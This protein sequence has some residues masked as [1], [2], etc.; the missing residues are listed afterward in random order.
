M[1]TNVPSPP[2]PFPKTIN[3]TL[4]PAGTQLHRVYSTV[5]EGNVFNP[6]TAKLNRF[7]PIFDRLGNV[8]P[9]LYAGATRQVAIYETL[10]HDAHIKGAKRQSLSAR[11]IEERRYGGWI[12]QRDLNLATL[13]APD[14]AGFGL[15]MDQLIATNSMYYPQTARWAEAFHRSHSDIE[16]LQWPSYRASPEL[17]YVLFGDRVASADLASAGNETLIRADAA[18]YE[19]V[20]ECGRRVGVRVHR[21]KPP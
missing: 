3:A 10:F 18:L 13:H 20:I 2:N 8:V 6:N 11:K 12:T 15:T 21:S 1:S 9:I 17:A 4:L 7:S 16:G 19:E 14:L 5:H